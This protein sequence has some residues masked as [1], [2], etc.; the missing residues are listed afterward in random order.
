[1]KLHSKRK[2]K[3]GSGRRRKF[4]WRKNVVS[5]KFYFSSTFER[6]KV[7]NIIYF[8]TGLLLIHFRTLYVHTCR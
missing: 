6:L 1:M 3:I 7:E 4:R 2:K 5:W 8:Q